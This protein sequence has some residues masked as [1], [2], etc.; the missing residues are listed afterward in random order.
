MLI[1]G[2]YSRLLPLKSC[3]IAYKRNLLVRS[4]VVFPLRFLFEE[5]RTVIATFLDL[6]TILH[7]VV[8]HIGLPGQ[9]IV[10]IILPSNPLKIINF[11]SNHDSWPHG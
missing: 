9:G 5:G 8:P 7:S 4:P 11:A 6:L 3:T 1:W 10:S 2:N